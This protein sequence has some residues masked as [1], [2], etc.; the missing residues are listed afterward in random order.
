MLKAIKYFIKI[1]FLIRFFICAASFRNKSVVSFYIEAVFEMDY[2][3]FQLQRGALY[4]L[5]I[6]AG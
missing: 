3:A 4:L 2:D 5:I 6:D 1:L